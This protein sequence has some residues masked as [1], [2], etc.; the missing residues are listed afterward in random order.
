MFQFIL[1]IS[2]LAA[3][4]VWLDAVRAAVSSLSGGYVRSL[5][6]DKRS[7]AEKWLDQQKEYGFILRSLSFLTTVTFTCYAYFHIIIEPFFTFKNNTLQEIKEGTVFFLILFLFLILKETLGT[8][9]ISFYRYNLLK[10]S[11]PIIQIIRIFLKPYELILMHSFNKASEREEDK[12]E[13]NKDSIA[14]NEILSLVEG[15]DNGELEEDEIR[16]IK[17]VFD[18]NDKSVKEAMTPRVDV[19][20]LDSQST[21]QEAIQKFVDSNLSR[22]PVYEETIDHIVGILYAKDFI[23]ESKLKGDLKTLYHAPHFVSESKRTRY[24]S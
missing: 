8:I 3:A 9:W 20:A 10:F 18:L 6:E 5:D 11:M 24:S 16:M 4:A 2:S 14:E 19:E 22:L 17:G 13:E 12:P 15:D 7:R 21:M 23:D 1:I